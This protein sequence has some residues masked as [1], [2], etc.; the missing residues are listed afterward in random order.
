MVGL[1]FPG[2]GAQAVGMGR[3]FFEKSEAAQLIFK[4]A[5][6][7]LRANLSKIIF[8][9]PEEV[10][11]QTVNSQPAIYVTSLAALAALKE[12]YPR[13]KIT[14]ACGLSLGEFSALAALEVFT[15]EEGLRLVQK[16]GQWMEEAA[17][18]MKGSMVSILGLPLE[19]CREVARDAKVEVANINSPEQIVLSGELTAIEKA[20]KLAEEK[21]AKRAIILK[22]SGAFHSSLMKEAGDKLQNLLAQVKFRPPKSLFL[23]NV[24]GNFERDPEKIKENLWLQV[25]CSVEWVQT[26]KNL[27][28]RGERYF[29]EL[30]PGKVLKGLAKKTQAEIQVEPL[31]TET[32]LA[33]ILETLKSREE[34][35]HASER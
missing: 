13:L 9:G 30:A 10:L 19:A 22:V 34:A 3:I 33:K 4:K 27:T 24:T 7:I 20:A 29:I 15:F 26:L 25:T 5:D 8:E 28:A 23:S 2:Q 17:R 1:F 35:L 21:G 12:K 16:R 32:D 6:E 11:T 14:S 18:K 31:E